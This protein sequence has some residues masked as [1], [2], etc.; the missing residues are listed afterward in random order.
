M[1]NILKTKGTQAGTI[2][3]KATETFPKHLF[4]KLVLW[5]N[6][7]IT[8]C[9]QEVQKPFSFEQYISETVSMLFTPVSLTTVECLW[10]FI[11]LR[12]NKNP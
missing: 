4:F 8:T 5:A 7:D 11:L 2:V 3:S 10:N 6:I 1:A 12:H 9:P